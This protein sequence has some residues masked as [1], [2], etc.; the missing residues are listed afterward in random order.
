[1][2]RFSRIIQLTVSLAVV[3]LFWLIYPG[4][5]VIAATAAGLLYVAAS[6]LALRGGKPAARIAFTLSAITAALTTLAVLRFAG[7]GFNYLSGN[8][9]SHG[10]IYWPPYAFLAIA[11]GAALAV[12]LQ[13]VA[14]RFGRG[15]T[16]QS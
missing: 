6:L 1:M 5:M 8:F 9:E 16:V 7:N 14:M 13:V 11:I 3:G 15:G 10:G 2:A 12:M 4:V